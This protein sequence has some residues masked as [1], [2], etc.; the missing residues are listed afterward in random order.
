MHQTE[1]HMDYLNKIKH[2]D[3]NT[4]AGLVGLK[5]IGFQETSIKD[6]SPSLFKGLIGLEK[7]RLCNKQ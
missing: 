4:F 6:S 3:S 5:N 7:N 2:I 1:I